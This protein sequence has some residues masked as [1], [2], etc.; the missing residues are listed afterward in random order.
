MHQNAAAQKCCLSGKELNPLWLAYT[1][2]LYGGSEQQCISV[3]STETKQE[4]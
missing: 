2:F 3:N 1:P 4:I